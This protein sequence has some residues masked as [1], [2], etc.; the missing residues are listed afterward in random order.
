MCAKKSTISLVCKECEESFQ[1]SKKEY[2]RRI[3]L[4]GPSIKF[5]CSRSCSSRH[6]NR[7]YSKE[8]KERMIEGLKRYHQEAKINGV[9]RNRRNYRRFSYYLRKARTRSK[10][11][12]WKKSD[13]TNSYLEELWEIQDGKCAFSGLPLNVNAGHGNYPS[14]FSLASL[15]RIDA[16]EGY[17]RGNVQFVCTPLNYAKSNSG[18]TEFVE[19]LNHLV[20]SMK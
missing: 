12:P 2:D 7:H 3:R 4:H 11:K 17:I 5:F 18:N 10:G 14:H 20:E 6:R 16:N 9:D 13:L 19:F 15:D 8:T 1:K